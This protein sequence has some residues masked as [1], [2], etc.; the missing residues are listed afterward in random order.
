MEARLEVLE[1]GFEGLLALRQTLEQNVEEERRE[2]METRKQLQAMAETR[3]EISAREDFKSAV[4]QRF[5]PS[6]LQ[7]PFE[8]VLS[9]KQTGPVEEHRSSLSY[10]QAL[11]NVLNPAYLKHIFLNGLKEVIWVELKLHTVEGLSER[12]DYAQKD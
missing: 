9:L 5:Q 6:M 4:I 7:S 12:R 10:M 11:L 8:L 3:R 1:R 2:R